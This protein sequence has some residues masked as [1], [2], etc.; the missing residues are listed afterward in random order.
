MKKL[1]IPSIID[2][3]RRY[4]GCSYDND[5]PNFFI[6]L[7]GL[8]IYDREALIRDYNLTSEILSDEFLLRDTYRFAPMFRVDIIKEIRWFFESMNNRQ[9]SKEIKNL[10]PEQLY[11]YFEEHIELN[12]GDRRR[13]YEHEKQCL[14]AAAVDWCKSLNISYTIAVVQ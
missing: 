9:I 13:W 7:D 14:T 4:V 3:G 2:Y 12:L 8:E 6:D 1:D 10:D 11:L 5:E